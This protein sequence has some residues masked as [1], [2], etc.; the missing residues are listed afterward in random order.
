MAQNSRGN[1]V[2]FGVRYN[3]RTDDF[4]PQRSQEEWLLRTTGCISWSVEIDVSGQLGG[5]NQR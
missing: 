3:P 1:L 5:G 4:F 2:S